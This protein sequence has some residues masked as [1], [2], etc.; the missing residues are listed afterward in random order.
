MNLSASTLISHRAFAQTH[1]HRGT[2]LCTNK[3]KHARILKKRQKENKNAHTQIHSSV[4]SAAG[5]NKTSAQSAER[6]NAQT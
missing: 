1:N 6:S 2:H 5:I 3:V 4:K